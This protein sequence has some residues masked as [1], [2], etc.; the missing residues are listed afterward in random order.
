MLAKIPPQTATVEVEGETFDIRS[1]TRAEAA[2]FQKLVADGISLADLEIG[3]IA[4]ATDT[5]RDE[6]KAWYEATPSAAVDALI[7]AIKDLSR[8]DDGAQ[9]SG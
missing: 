9:K 3:F 7:N 4:A 8:L 5:P 2:R 6:A 1:L